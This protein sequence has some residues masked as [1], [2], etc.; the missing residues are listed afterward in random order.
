[1]FG[2]ELIEKMNESRQSKLCGALRS[3]QEGANSENLIFLINS[4]RISA[5]LSNSRD[6]IEGKIFENLGLK[7]GEPEFLYQISREFSL[8]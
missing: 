5:S 4:Q 3:V 7:F 1:M 6:K 8:P 2:S